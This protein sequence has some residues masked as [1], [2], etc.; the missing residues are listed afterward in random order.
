MAYPNLHPFSVFLTVVLT[1]DQPPTHM[2]VEEEH[3]VAVLLKMA[4]FSLAEVSAHIH[5]YA[6]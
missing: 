6:R 4:Y 5:D 3:V 1:N 2:V